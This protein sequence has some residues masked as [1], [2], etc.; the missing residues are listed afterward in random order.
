MAKVQ[1]N[2]VYLELNEPLT[3][4]VKLTH[5]Q[6]SNEK[7][8]IRFMSD[9]TSITLEHRALEYM[10]MERITHFFFPSLFAANVWPK[11]EAHPS[12]YAGAP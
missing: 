11:N 8:F 9:R 12:S 5:V 2:T 4:F 3:H 10:N 6:V 1:G 7:Y